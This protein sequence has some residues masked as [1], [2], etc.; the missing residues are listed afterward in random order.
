MLNARL[1]AVAAA[2]PASYVSGEHFARLYGQKDSER[3]D[4]LAGLDRR[5]RL[6]P[7]AQPVDLALRASRAALAHAGLRGQ[8]LDALVYVTQTPEYRAPA[9]A[10]ILQTRLEL[11]LES[12]AFDVNLGCSGYVYGLALASGLVRAGVRRRVL[13]VVGDAPSRI[14]SDA[15]RSMGPLFGDAMSAS[16][17]EAS[18]DEKDSFGPFE[19]GTDGRGWADLVAPGGQC[20]YPDAESFART[21]V[22]ELEHVADPR[23]L[24]MKGGDVFTFTLTRVPE[25][26]AR[27]IASARTTLDAIDYVVLH[28]ANRAML[29]QIRR[30]AKIPPE[31]VLYSLEQYGN[32]S[33]ASVPVT[34][35]HAL[36]GRGPACLSLLLVGFG[37]GYSWGA[38]VAEVDTSA[39]GP[40]VSF[41]P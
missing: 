3:I 37:V 23:C 39:I 34:V 31:K 1:R 11:P 7:S 8:D 4:K 36:H 17:V 38:T 5:P 24:T 25:L 40:V 19:L 27:A 14:V 16:I 15:D 29:E 33:G 28:Q 41:E 13:L 21:R 6:Q 35:C 20:A 2:V 18:A 10:C 22:P 32:T 9:T 26:V 12:A 30:K